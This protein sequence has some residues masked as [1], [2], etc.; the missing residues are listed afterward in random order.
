MKL[1]KARLRQI[2]R[3]VIEEVNLYHDEKGH[4]TSKSPNAIRSISRPAAKKNNVDD[5]YVGK[6]IVANNP[7]KVRKKMGLS[8]CGSVDI[9]DGKRKHPVKSCKD[10]PK[11]YQNE[12]IILSEDSLDEADEKELRQAVAFCQKRGMFRANKIISDFLKR[13]NAAALASKGSLYK[14]AKG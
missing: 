10:F 13:T 8:D 6:A 7:E 2:I 12:D 14:K 9:D 1:S 5:K 11:N 3:E 4:W